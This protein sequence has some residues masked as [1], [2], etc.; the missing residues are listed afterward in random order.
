MVQE[1]EEFYDDVHSEFIQFGEIVNFKVCRNSSPHL[2]GNVYV[3]YVSQESAMVAYNHMNGRFYAKKQISCE[4]VGVHKWKLAICGEFM[5]TYYKTC[6]H[7][8]ACNFLH[9]F[10]NPRREYE[11]A[12]T[13]RPPPRFWQRKM[14]K[15]FGHAQIS[16]EDVDEKS[17]THRESTRDTD[18]A[19]HRD[20]R[21]LSYDDDRRRDRHMRDSAREDKQR[22]SRS[23]RERKYY[24]DERKDRTRRG[25]SKCR[26]SKE[27][28]YDSRRREKEV[29]DF[30]HDDD[31]TRDKS[32]SRSVHGDE[33][34]CINDERWIAG[35]DDH[36]ETDD[37]DRDRR[38]DRR[39][40]SATYEDDDDGSHSSRYSPTPS[41]HS[42]SRSHRHRSRRRSRS[43]SSHRARRSM[44]RDRS[45]SRRARSQDGYYSSS[46]EQEDRHSKETRHRKERAS[47][48]SK[49]LRHA[50]KR[51]GDDMHDSQLAS[52]RRGDEVVGKRHSS[53]DNQKASKIL[54]SDDIRSRY[55]KD[56]EGTVAGMVS[57]ANASCSSSLAKLET[58]SSRK[59]SLD[60]ENLNQ[61]TDGNRSSSSTVTGLN[62]DLSTDD[63]QKSTSEW[64]SWRKT[65]KVKLGLKEKPM[66][67]II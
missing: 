64:Q 22:R 8:T 52:E 53:E 26:D 65:K 4:F 36:L 24:E 57:D 12:D 31:S 49:R 20:D 51:S 44:S 59:A 47:K 35:D 62:L 27:K 6:S 25:S 19:R 45:T 34:G 18:R 38:R 40:R 43:P 37:K 16:D 7:G 13:D 66:R 50:A 10:E 55:P 15:L 60:G 28:S 42:H 1:Y 54:E 63:V 9:C 61:E 11:W 17:R 56:L 41:H 2:R 21:E 46:E 14:A 48:E 67:V 5:R 3:H 29:R 58:Q 32:A 23:D 33:P 30:T 39:H